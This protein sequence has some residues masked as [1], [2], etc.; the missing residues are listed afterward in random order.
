M[1]GSRVMHFGALRTDRERMDKCM[2][3]QQL[4]DNKPTKPEHQNWLMRQR[5][6]EKELG[7][8]FRFNS[9]L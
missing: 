3:D 5:N 6:R 1:K 2:K 7:P 4:I 9:T 8:E